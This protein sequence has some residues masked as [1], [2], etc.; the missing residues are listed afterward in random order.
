MWDA[1]RGSYVAAVLG[2]L[3]LRGARIDEVTA[4]MTPEIF[5]RFGLPAELPAEVP[6]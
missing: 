6:A 3:T 1:A 2:V 4:F 5:P